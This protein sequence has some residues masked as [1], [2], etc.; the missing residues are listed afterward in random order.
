M[1]NGTRRILGIPRDA[2]SATEA[3]W[4]GAFQLTESRLEQDIKAQADSLASVLEHQLGAGAA[5]I[6]EAALQIRSCSKVLITGMGASLYAAIPLKYFLCARGIDAALVEAG[7]LLHYL[8]QAYRDAL[9]IIVSRSGE[10]VE[11]ARLITLLSPLQKII[12]VSNEPASLLSR[13]AGISLHIGSM[14]D[15]MVAI[16]T[17]TGTLLTLHVLGA[18]VDD[19]V[20]FSEREM[21]AWIRE[22]AGLVSRSLASPNE[23]DSFLECESPVHLLARGPSLA[24]ALEGALLFNEI[25]KHP[26]IGMPSA[27]FRHGPVE[28][29]DRSFR[30]FVFAPA[31]PTRDLNLALVRDLKDFGGR[32]TVI[33]PLPMGQVATGWCDIPECPETLAPLFEIVP[34]QVA[35]LR[36]AQLRGIVP[37]S[38]RYAPQVARDEAS[39]SRT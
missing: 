2:G 30:G 32:V 22:L 8:H 11:I 26:S 34:V 18:A 7:E 1:A 28:L 16:Q 36:M 38:F 10:S 21:A 5:C 6:Q 37:G 20:S 4:I 13:K 25:A 39:F 33:G 35:A 19:P 12:G 23:W 3:D 27:S 31:G 9:V 14:S 29:V 15:E 17:Y 24:S